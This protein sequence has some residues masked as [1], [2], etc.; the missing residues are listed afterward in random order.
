VSEQH[1]NLFA[2]VAGDL[3]GFGFGDVTGEITSAFVD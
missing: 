3:V 1:F 2:L